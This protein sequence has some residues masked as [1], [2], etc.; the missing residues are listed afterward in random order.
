MWLFVE[1]PSLN[2]GVVSFEWL[3]L[4]NGVVNFRMSTIENRRGYL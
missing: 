1:W 4:R 2:M 3:P